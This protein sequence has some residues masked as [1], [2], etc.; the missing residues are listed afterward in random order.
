MESG[1]R[2]FARGSILALVGLAAIAS[3]YGGWA[4]SGALLKLRSAHLPVTALADATRPA[5]AS[6]ESA[7]S[8]PASV[9]IFAV[10]DPISSRCSEAVCEADAAFA[11]DCL[12]C[13]GPNPVF[14]AEPAGFVVSDPSD[15]ATDLFGP[16]DGLDALELAS[17][18]PGATAPATP[19]ISTA[20]MV[21]LGIFMLT[22]GRTGRRRWASWKAPWR[23]PTLAPAS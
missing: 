11:E 9:E 18:E 17:L 10:R 8:P 21:A 12:S 16:Q 5:V 1:M 15:A 2:F 6:R 3:A 14:A 4:G 20:A 22:A 19:E 23:Q 13:A 7:A